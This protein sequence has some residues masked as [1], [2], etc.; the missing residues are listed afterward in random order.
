MDI[1]GLLKAAFTAFSDFVGLTKLME[2]WFKKTT[3]EKID[4]AEKKIDEE[5]DRFKENGGRE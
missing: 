5:E 3:Q 1:I 2:K 4:E